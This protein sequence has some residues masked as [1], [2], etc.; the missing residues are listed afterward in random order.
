MAQSRASV[1]ARQTRAVLALLSA[2]SHEEAA[3]AAGISHT[4][5]Y[6]WLAHDELFIDA[7]REARRVAV[8]QA[9]ARLQQSSSEAV[10]VLRSIMQGQG[11]P[12][13]ARVTAARTV[14]EMSLKAVELEE[15]A[16]RLAALEEFVGEGRDV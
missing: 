15:I 6:R 7:Y 10:E 3:Q 9:I 16:G 14:L 12:A 2:P 1:T 13:A 5:L 11:H 8:E 4:T